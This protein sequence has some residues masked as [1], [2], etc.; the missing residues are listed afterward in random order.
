MVCTAL[1]VIAYALALG[2]GITSE[3]VAERYGVFRDSSRMSTP[4]AATSAQLLH[5]LPANL[6]HRLCLWTPSGRTLRR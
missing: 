4:R 1:L 6:T 5:G 2:T 3:N